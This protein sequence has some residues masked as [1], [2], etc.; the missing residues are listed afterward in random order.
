MIGGTGP[1]GVPLVRALVDAGH[2]VTLCNRG[3][4]PSPDT[5]DSVATVTADPYDEV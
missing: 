4:H 5:P 1:T 3:L 2:T